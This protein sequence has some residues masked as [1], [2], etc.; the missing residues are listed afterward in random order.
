MNR[1]LRFIYLN[2]YAILLLAAG[3]ACLLVLTRKVH[4]LLFCL[5]IF[6]SIM[7]FVNAV[8]LFS[9]WN[10]KKRKYQ[11]LI[12]KNKNEFHEET[13]EIFMQAPCG[14]LLT[15]AVLCDLNQKTQYRNLLKY[16]ESL[17]SNL[18]KNCVPQKT[19]V[20]VNKDVLGI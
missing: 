9:T 7:C 5:L 16:R 17:L 12:A 19:I 8:R 6:C 4:L 1:F 2:I 11:I 20:Y 13:F 3:F 14:R 15:R 18:K 10:D